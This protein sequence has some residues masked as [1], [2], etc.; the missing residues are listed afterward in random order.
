L[1][2]TGAANSTATLTAS[3]SGTYLTAKVRY[4][5]EEDYD[6]A[7][8]RAQVGGVWKD[9]ATNLSTTTDPNGGNPSHTG[10]TG[11]STGFADGAWVSLTATLPAGTTAVQFAY[12]NDPAVFGEGLGVDSV[13]STARPWPTLPGRSSGSRRPSTV[14][15]SSRSSTRT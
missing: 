2:T 3:A 9:V 4:D 13:R 7:F 8:L 12:T 1:W 6:Y 10:I 11:T 14:S 15:S 5:I